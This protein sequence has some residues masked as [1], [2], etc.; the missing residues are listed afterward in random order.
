M[1]AVI[2]KYYLVTDTH[3]G[4]AGIQ[5][6][7]GRPPE[8]KEL[9]IKRWRATVMP[10]D[11]VFHLGDVIWGNQQELK[12]IMDQLPGTKIL[13]RGNHDASRS[14]NWFITAGFSVVVD[15]VQIKDVILSHVP[16]SLSPQQVKDGIINIHGHFHNADPKRWEKPYKGEVTENHFLLSFEEVDYFPISLDKAR[17]RQKVIPTADRIK[18][19]IR[20]TNLQSEK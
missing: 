15:R 1:K 13:V 14:N 4:H 19:G 10:Y 6:W 20:N 18:N 8:F 5:Q 17:K 11:I 16:I 12:V 3:F 9:I 7:C 2:S